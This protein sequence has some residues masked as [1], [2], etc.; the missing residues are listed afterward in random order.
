MAFNFDLFFGKKSDTS[1]ADNLEVS[2]D[3]S[4]IFKMFEESNITL[5]QEA[6]DIINQ[7]YLDGYISSENLKRLLDIINEA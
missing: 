6:K 2:D 7:A 4:D 5:N 3:V 1:S